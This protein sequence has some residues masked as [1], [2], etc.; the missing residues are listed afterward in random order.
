MC[1]RTDAKQ[2]G[3]YPNQKA[4]S[5]NFAY[6]IGGKMGIDLGPCAKFTL[7]HLMDVETGEERLNTGTNTKGLFSQTVTIF[8][9]GPPKLER[10]S[11]APK[12]AQL[13]LRPQSIEKEETNETKEQTNGSKQDIPKTLGDLA[14]VLRS[15]NAGPYEITF[16]V[17]FETEKT[18]DLV[19]KSNILE[20]GVVA[21]LLDVTE[22][23]I[24]WSGFFDQAR[25]YKVTIPRMW[26]GKPVPNG[27]FMEQDVHA[28]QKYLG[29]LNM[30]LNDEF[31][32]LWRDSHGA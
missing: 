26:K 12:Q 3:S 4:T 6:G 15:K 24:I 30:K 31:I 2:H 17:I 18:C 27:G 28:S 20:K 10:A 23:D 7:Y 21:K 8:G 19:K 14:G 13:I 25:A 11:D 16:D 29:L 32:Q 1:E 22:E 9:Q 5:G